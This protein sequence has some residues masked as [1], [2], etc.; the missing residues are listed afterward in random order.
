MITSLQ[1]Q[2]VKDAAKLR[3][4]R[5]RQKQQRIIVDGVREIRRAIAADLEWDEA[6]VCEELL[7]PALVGKPPAAPAEIVA[8]LKQ[9]G[10]E[11]VPVTREVFAKLAFGDRTEGIV[12]VARTPR[13]TL[14]ELKLPSQ[15][16][17]AVL[18]RIEKPGKVGAILRSADAAGISAVLLADAGTDLLNPNAIR[19]SQG[20]VF[21]LPIAVADGDTLR[22]WLRE[23]RFRIFAARVDAQLDYTKANWT[24]PAAIVLGSEADGLSDCWQGDDVTAIR[25]PMRGTVDSLNVSV[26]AAVL[27]YEALRRPD[28][29]G[30]A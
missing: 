18:E 5:A 17:V 15:P 20:A 9:A 12:A 8:L 22:A 21:T 29:K 11:I 3:D 7:H 10:A 16:I 28:R 4:H 13:R 24:A 1:N 2:R 26:T 14:E 19:A 6:F 27:F 25:L 30:E 23:R